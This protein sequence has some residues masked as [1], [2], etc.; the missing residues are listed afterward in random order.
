MIAQEQMIQVAA[1]NVQKLRLIDVWRV[2]DSCP[3]SHSNINMTCRKVATY[4][5]RHRPDLAE[6]VNSYLKETLA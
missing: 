1:D 6:E 2:L 5:K 4:I 3:L